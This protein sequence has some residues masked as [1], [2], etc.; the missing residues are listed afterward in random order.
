MKELTQLQK[1]A[2]TK[3]DE[4]IMP[5]HPSEER[6]RRKWLDSLATHLQRADGMIHGEVIKKILKDGGFPA[7]ETNDFIK[8]WD[9]A[10]SEFDDLKMA[11]LQ[12]Y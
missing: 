3:V 9:K 10:Q 5:G 6:A 2:E 11:L 1:L 12:E 7:T 4:A 8:A